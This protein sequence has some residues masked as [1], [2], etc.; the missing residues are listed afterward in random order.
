LSGHVH[1]SPF[2]PDGSWY[3]RLGATWVFNTGRLPG[4]PPTHIVLDLD[5][6]NAFWLAPGEAQAI[7]LNAP[8][9]RPAAPVTEPPAWLT[10][11]GLIADP[12]RAR[13]LS[14]AG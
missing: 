13:S 4:R 12:S 11:L 7:D 3:D 5:G 6:G 10:S 14:A 8:L 9:Q 2:I 1:Q